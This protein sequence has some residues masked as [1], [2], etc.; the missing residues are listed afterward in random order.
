V[1]GPGAGRIDIMV[2]D[3]P[4]PGVV[5]AEYAGCG[6][7]R[8]GGDQVH[9]MSFKE[10]RE[11]AARAR[12]RHADLPDAAGSASDAWH[13]RIQ[14]GLVLPEVQMPPRQ[15][16]CV[17]DRTTCRAAGRAGEQRPLVE[18]D[19]DVQSLRHRIEAGSGNK[20]RVLQPQGRLKR[21]KIPHIRR[22]AK[23][24]QPHARAGAMVQSLPTPERNLAV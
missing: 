13:A 15:R 20:P 11:A 14:V 17:V 2:D 22:P 8:H 16:P 12:P 24:N 6:G 3:P 23:F 7:N 19:V 9:D 5:L 21:L 18:R 4:Q 10:Q 1:I